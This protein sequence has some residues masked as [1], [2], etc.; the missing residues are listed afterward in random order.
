MLKGVTESG[1]EFELLDSLKDDMEYLDLAVRADEGDLTALP[2]LVTHML[3]KEG[4][5]RLFDHCRNDDGIASTQGVMKEVKNIFDIIGET[6]KD[7]KN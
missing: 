3:G 1:F 5:K 6:D 7:I 2:G 4:K